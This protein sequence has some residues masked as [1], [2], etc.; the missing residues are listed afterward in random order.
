MQSLR[1]IVS[2][3]IT[4]PHLNATIIFKSFSTKTPKKD[5]DDEWNDAWET[6]WLPPDL[7]P[8]DRPPW[9]ADVNFGSNDSNTIVLPSDADAETKAFVEDMNE[10][11]DERRKKTK[12][13]D[14]GGGGGNEKLYSLE[15][16][17]KDYRLKKQRI[18]AGLWMKE[19]EKQEEANLAGGA[20][21]DIDRLLDSCSELYKMV[22]SSCGYLNYKYWMSSHRIFDSTS[23][24][25]DNAKI[26]SSSEFKNKPDGWETTAKEQDGNVWEMSQREE[27]ILLQEF[28]RRI[29][30]CKFQIASFIKTHIFSRRRPIDGWKHMIEEIGPNARKGKGSV[31]RL[32]SLSDPSTQPFKEEKPPSSSRLTPLRGRGYSICDDPKQAFGVFNI[33]RARGLLLDQFSYIT[34]LKACA[35]DHESAA[36]HGQVIHGLV[37]KSG[38]VLFINVKNTLL[39]F[40][41][42]RGK[43]G[44]AHKL[45]DEYPHINDLVS[46][47]TLMGGYFHVSQPTVVVNLFRQICRS[48]LRISASTVLSILFAVGDLGNL[49][50]G[51]SLHGHCIKI[52]FNS[53]LNVVTA[54]IDMYAKLED[55]DSGRRIF[56]EA[57]EKD[58]ILWNCMIDNLCYLWILTLGQCIVD[59]VEEEV[60]ALD[61]NLGT[62]MVDIYGVHGQ[63]RN[64]VTLFYRMEDEGVRPNEVTFL[65]VLSACSHGGLVEEGMEILERMVIE[66]G[67]SPKIEHYGCLVDLLGRAGLLEEAH[68]LIKSLPIKVDA[69]AWRALLSACRVYGN[70]KLGEYVNSVL[71][72]MNDEHPTDTILVSSTYAIAGRQPNQIRMHEVEKEKIN[73]QVGNRSIGK[74]EEKMMKEA[75]RSAIEM[76][77]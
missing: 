27:D 59:Y 9:E 67:F 12:D 10:N 51:E 38:H 34:A 28:D 50:G 37:A 44:D 45:F 43:I 16:M 13:N 73:K 77:I 53:N 32:P 60:L 62:A 47:N 25:L 69:T 21:D 46:L 70:I 29:A 72:E 57:S 63:A 40:Y 17:K 68:N 31:P 56:D 15:N 65:A 33:L 4:K 30:F 19:I 75:G 1:R 52:G 6:A 11:W 7:S 35:R 24:D 39:H 14:D 48:D 74:E 66:Y 5:G 76:V 23:T 20:A 36:V 71:I 55:I 54:L 18:H 42:V 8:K 49:R 58:V 22:L 26:P 41:C 64:A 61:A 2:K 3:S